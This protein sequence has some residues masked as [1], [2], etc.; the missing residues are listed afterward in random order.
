MR[1]NPNARLVGR[2]IEPAQASKSP[3]RNATITTTINE[4]D[5]RR[6]LGVEKPSSKPKIPNSY[7]QLLNLDPQDLID[8]FNVKVGE[9]AEFAE[10]DFVVSPSMLEHRIR[11]LQRMIA[12]SKQIIEGMA[13]RIIKIRRGKEDPLLDD[14][15]TR[16]KY[17]REENARVARCNA[18]LFHYRAAFRSGK[19]YHESVWRWVTKPVYFHDLVD[20]LMAFP[21]KTWEREERTPVLTGGLLTHERVEM[22]EYFRRGFCDLDAYRKIMTLGVD[23]LSELGESHAQMEMMWKIV[24]RWENAIILQAV[25]HGVIG[26]RRDL[27]DLLGLGDILDANDEPI[28]AD[29]TEDALA[30]KTGGACYGGRIKSEGYRYRYGRLTQR[31]L[32]S[33][34]KPLRN[35]KDGSA[36]YEDSG[37]NSL[38]DINDDAESYDPR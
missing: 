4:D 34:D 22:V 9:F 30:I 8:F 38:R 26:V 1:S 14:K 24:K 6:S 11:R 17:K 15:A 3:V 27:A 31:A 2:E 7:R 18:R 21:V 13:S 35:I 16:E 5:L 29:T 23:A 20:D 33:F 12:C 32:S 37:F 19:D 28:L 25:R 36:G 10:V